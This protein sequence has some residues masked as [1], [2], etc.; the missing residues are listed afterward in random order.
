MADGW[1][2][3]GIG[4]ALYADVEALARRRDGGGGRSRGGGGGGGAA[5]D[6]SGVHVAVD[7]ITCEVNLAPPN[8]GSRA[9][10]ERLG[11]VG[12]GERWDEGGGTRGADDGEGSAVTSARGSDQP[13]ASRR[14][15]LARELPAQR[16]EQDHPS[17]MAAAARRRT[18]P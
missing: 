5:D 17:P 18:G 16:H 2:G 8:P 13:A 15:A 9:F 6:A 4:R 14:S 7:W 1:R 10:P 3:H 11:F 12:V